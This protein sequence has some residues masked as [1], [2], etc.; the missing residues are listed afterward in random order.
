MAV[1]NHGL[2]PRSLSLLMALMV[3][4][5]CSSQN[6]PSQARDGTN[7]ATDATRQADAAKKTIAIGIVV[8]FLAF[9]LADT[10]SGSG[11][12]IQLQEI[13]L[14]GLVTSGFDSPAPEP[15]VAARIPSL[16]DGSM[17]IEADGRM[18]VTW[19]LRPDVRWAD[20][21]PV[22]ADDFAFGF[23]VQNDGR[24]SF[25][26]GALGRRVQS[27]TAQ[28][29]RT[30]VMVWNEP[31][32]QAASVG[33]APNALQP[34]PRHVL[35]A[36]YASGPVEAFEN[37]SYWTSEFFH[38][39]P[40]RPVSFDPQSESVFEAVAH[41]FL[42][43]PKVGTLVV[44]KLGDPNAAY[45]ALLGG[46]IDMAVSN[47]ITPAIALELR[48]RWA[49]SGEGT[50]HIGPGVTQFVA[51]QFSPE[52]Q[53]EPAFLDPA[54]RKGLYHAIDREGWAD[55]TMGGKVAGTMATALLPANHHL[56]SY[57]TD[58]L[59]AYRY[60]PR[61]AMALLEE[62]GWRRGTD[63]FLTHS[64]DGRRF[65]ALVWSTNENEAAILAD[66]WKQAGLDTSVYVMP[67]ARQSDQ[68]FW[69]SF[70]NVEITS[71]GYGDTILERMDCAFSP[72]A[73]NGY[74]G[75]NRGHYCNR[76]AMEP[77]LA[78]YRTS[79]AR[80]EQGAAIRRIAELVAEDLPVWPVYFAITRIPVA[81]NVL[82]MQDYAGG[83][84]G[85]DMYGSFY[86]NAHLWDRIGSTDP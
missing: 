9:S 35:Q 17:R 58:S 12:G 72:T 40:Y 32:Y 70:P 77:L 19:Q 86:R 75:D 21:H 50:V 60:D 55:V 3:V 30:L 85:A 46:S 61:Q 34:L 81:K 45:A 66:M 51:P 2:A 43:A 23:E 8:P 63:G 78:Q 24:L 54:V 7:P 56:A 76:A 29:E 14:Q 69:Q 83:A 49:S 53:R 47:A 68:Q 11:S 44:R 31:Y 37:H 42:G 67:R 62:A 18:V 59:A 39:G 38:I 73:A 4:V 71:R 33:T 20:G 82:A 65:N 5:A 6:A 28:D 36:A 64:L 48:E 22:T 26:R 79:L 10:Q 74:A 57:V 13:W 41:Y 1:A 27:V 25:G 16:D 15:R 84:Q 52:L 80:P